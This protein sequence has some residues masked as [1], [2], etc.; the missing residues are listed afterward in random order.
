MHSKLIF[1]IE[2]INKQ[3]VNKIIYL[4]IIIITTTT[5]IIIDNNYIQRGFLGAFVSL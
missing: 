1:F 5:I 3:K 4:L 2:N